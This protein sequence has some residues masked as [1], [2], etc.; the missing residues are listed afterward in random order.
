MLSVILLSML[1]ILISTLSVNSHLI[2][3]NNWRWPLNLN[4]IYVA[5][6]TGARSGLLI[7][8][9]EKLSLL[10]LTGLITLVLWMWRM[11]LVL[12]KNNLL[13]C[14]GCVSLLKWIEA[15]T[16]PLLLKRPSRNNEP[17]FVWWSSFLQRS[18]CISLNLPYG[19]T[20]NTVVLCGQILLA[21][22]WKCWI[23]YIHRYVGLLMLHF[24]LLLNSWLM[25]KMLPS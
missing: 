17:W 4:L 13:T 9:L 21:V 7:S 16:L 14:C 25:F 11:R 20:W 2:C 6:W 24:L 1:M 15:L 22:T 23:N 19:L 5:L 10:R 12:R 8:N 18:F 3:D